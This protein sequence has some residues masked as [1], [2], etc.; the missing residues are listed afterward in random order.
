MSEVAKYCW[1]E[2]ADWCQD[3][4]VSLEWQEDWMFWWDCWKT[5]IDSKL[6]YLGDSNE[7]A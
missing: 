4:G 5:A 1:D 6:K 3:E 7:V 2:F